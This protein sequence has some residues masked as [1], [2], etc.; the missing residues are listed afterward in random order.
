MT[1][2]VLDIMNYLSSNYSCHPVQYKE[3]IMDSSV[4]ELSLEQ[5]FQIKLMEESSQQLTHDQIQNLLLQASRLLMIKD[6][7]IRSLIK[8][9]IL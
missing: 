1:I 9:Q 6:N 8:K 4:F 7:V 2:K 3:T 5:E